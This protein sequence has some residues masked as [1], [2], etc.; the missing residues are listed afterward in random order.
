MKKHSGRSTSLWEVMS[1]NKL[2]ES[3]AK[4]R[5]QFLSKQNKDEPEQQKP[6]VQA[7]PPPQEK[8]QPQPQWSSKP[9]MFQANEGRIELSLPYAVAVLFSLSVIVAVLVA[10][11]I[12][13]EFAGPGGT[14]VDNSSQQA[15]ASDGGQA[16]SRADITS[17]GSGT[18]VEP[19]TDFTVEGAAQSTVS[20]GSTSSSGSGQSALSHDKDHVIIIAVYQVKRDLEP[21]RDFFNANGMPTEIVHRGNWYYLQT[22][23]RYDSP[24]RRGSDGYYALQQV[25]R[26]GK[27]Y[28]AP[29]GYESFKANQFQDAYGM[30]IEKR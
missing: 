18:Q 17:S 16:Q 15:S 26:I 27:K 9:A 28:D 5:A 19:K 3:Q 1:K 29:T 12:G 24:L 4:V 7:A 2:K 23:N 25:K 30:N 8:P 21:V 22:K 13:Q 6:A 11:R 20:G 14:P 10:F